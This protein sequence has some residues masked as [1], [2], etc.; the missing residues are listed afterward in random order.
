MYSRLATAV[1]SILFFTAPL[2]AEVDHREFLSGTIVSGEEA[3]R[4]CL[5]C[6]QEQA[7]EIM[8]T[9]HWTWSSE[10]KVAGN[11]KV[12]LGKKNAINNFCVSVNANWP[13]CTSCHIGYGWKDA[14]FDFA[15]AGKVDCLVC[16]DTTGTY[17]KD[18]AAAGQPAEGVNLL[19][20]AQQVGKPSRATCGA[21]HFFGGGGDAVKHGDLDSSM[22]NPSRQLDV[23]MAVDG[24]NFQCQDCH[25]TSEHK[26]SGRAMVVSPGGDDHI[27]C[28]K[29]H[30]AAPH[31]DSLLNRHFAAVACQTCHIPAFA[32]EMPTKT[33]WDWSTAGQERVVPK[34]QYGRPTYDQKKGDFTWGKN[35]IPT[36]RWYNGHAGAYLVGDKMNPQKVTELSYP[37]GNIKDGSA[38]I[39]PFKVHTGKQIYDKKYNY[40]IT[41]QVFGKEGYWKTFDWNRAAQIGMK[42]SGLTYSGDYGFAPTIMYWRINHMVAPKEQALGCLECHGDK[43]RL[44]WRALGYKGDPIAT[45][46]TV[47]MGRK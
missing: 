28:E 4:Q 43:G 36:Y 38:K 24:N 42:A 22:L 44:D 32:R 14:N 46:Q 7:A 27:G 5:G 17:Q 13:R 1:L 34:D 6:H 33:S 47:R 35:I 8:K 15:D 2:H 9:T 18:P 39:Y 12:D 19:F 3:T 29:C 11:G 45:R 16:H 41:P 23:H 40:F 30:D 37:E 25:T 10:Q 21:C 31:K 20:V 26:I